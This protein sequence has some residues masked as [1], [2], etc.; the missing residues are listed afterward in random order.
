VAESSTRILIVV[1]DPAM[2]RLVRAALESELD[3]VEAVGGLDGV[4]AFQSF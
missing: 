3:A 1:D 2:R 4:R